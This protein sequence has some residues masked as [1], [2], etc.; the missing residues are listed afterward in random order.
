MELAIENDLAR[1]REQDIGFEDITGVRFYG[2]LLTKSSAKD[3]YYSVLISLFLWICH[4]V[5]SIR[6]QEVMMHSSSENALV[7]VEG[8]SLIEHDAKLQLQ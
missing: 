1:K 6:S 7:V 4:A 2:S 5:S 8:Y 3:S